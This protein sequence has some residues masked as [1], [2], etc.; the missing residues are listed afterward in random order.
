MFAYDP[1]LW[2][3]NVFAELAI[4][5]EQNLDAFQVAGD[6]ANFASIELAVAPLDLV[7]PNEL[8]RTVVGAT[9]TIIDAIIR[10]TGN[11]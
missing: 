5:F 6:R 1:K 8:I 11:T 9:G 7:G 2:L 4:A 3:N 10:V